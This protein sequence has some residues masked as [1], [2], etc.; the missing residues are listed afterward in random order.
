MGM[1]AGKHRENRPEGLGRGNMKIK[2]PVNIHGIATHHHRH[3]HQQRRQRNGSNGTT[4]RRSTREEAHHPP[5]K[6]RL[7]DTKTL[8]RTFH[9]TLD[10]HPV[11]L[12]PPHQSTPHHT[13]HLRSAPPPEI[14]LISISME[15][16]PAGSTAARACPAGPQRWFQNRSAP[17]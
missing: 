5:F 15:H 17:S 4:Q 16:P 6:V 12:N 2:Q 7:P 8:C 11:S 10:L 13:H 9:S 14:L 3:Q 1:T